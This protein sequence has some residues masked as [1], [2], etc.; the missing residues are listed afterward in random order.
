MTRMTGSSALEVLYRDITNAE[1][2][3]VLP[4]GRVVYTDTYRGL[5]NVWAEGGREEIFAKVGGFPNGV[6]LGSDGLLYVANNG[7]ALG[8]LRSYDTG[9]GLIQRVAEGGRPEIVATEIDGR[10]LNRPNDIC[11]GPGG[12][13]YFTD[14]GQWNTERPDPGYLYVI[15]PDGRAETLLEVGGTYPN[16]IA[17]DLDGNVLWVESFTGRLRRLTASGDVDEL[18]T[19]APDHKPDGMAIDVDG[20]V[21]IATLNSGGLHIVPRDGGGAEFVDLGGTV[22]TNCAFRGTD[23]ILTDGGPERVNGES[24][25]YWGHGRLLR[26]PV[27]IGGMALHAGSIPATADAMRE[28]AVAP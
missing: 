12:D 15:H 2:P 1:G 5:L 24:W 17:V 22:L 4:D 7:G 25:T 28:R 23:L 16:G 10:P 9:P 20:N 11:F 8:G 19:F 21:Y 14:P 26:M 3:V 6:A 13:L 27:G 18:H